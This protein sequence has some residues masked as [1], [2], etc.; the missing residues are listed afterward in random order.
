MLQTCKHFDHYL[1]D[2]EWDGLQGG[3]VD[4]NGKLKI[5]TRRCIMLGLAFPTEATAPQ[6]PIVR[7]RIASARTYGLGGA[8]YDCIPKATSK[9]IVA[10]LLAAS[11]APYTPQDALCILRDLKCMMKSSRKACKMPMTR[12]DTFPATAQ[13]LQATRPELYQHAYPDEGPV[14]SR[15]Q[16]E[17]SHIILPARKTHSSVA[18]MS[19]RVA[20]SP[21]QQLVGRQPSQ[22]SAGRKRFCFGFCFGRCAIN[23]EMPQHKAEPTV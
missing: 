18:A 5:I 1:T 20:H 6:K 16:E 14:A 17:P 7:L 15:L 9:V 23:S 4:M 3:A 19:G 11:R 12:L 2:S 21:A 13:E 10:T 22:E 8:L